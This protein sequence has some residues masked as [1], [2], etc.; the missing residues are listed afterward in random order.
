[1]FNLPRPRKVKTTTT[2][3]FG[4]WSLDDLANASHRSVSWWQK[5]IK[6]YPEIRDFSNMETKQDYESWVFDAAK[7]NEWLIKKFVYKEV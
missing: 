7:A 5:N 3:V 1:M 2:A 6:K 4:T